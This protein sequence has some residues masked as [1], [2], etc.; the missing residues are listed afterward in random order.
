M[1]FKIASCHC[2]LSENRA[3]LA[4]VVPLNSIS[5]LP[6]GWPNLCHLHHPPSSRAQHSFLLL[7]SCKYWTM[8]R[9]LCWWKNAWWTRKTSSYVIVKW[10]NE[11]MKLLMCIRLVSFNFLFPSSFFFFHFSFP[12]TC[13]SVFDV[14]PNHLYFADGGNSRKSKKLADASVDGKALSQ[15]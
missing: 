4:E 1:K 6:L 7:I 14:E 3:A 10:C 13:F 5:T 15:L 8:L 9:K 11:I 12:F 2:A